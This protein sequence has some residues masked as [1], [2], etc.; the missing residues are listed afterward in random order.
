MQAVKDQLYASLIGEI[1]DYLSRI[2]LVANT[3]VNN[4]ILNVIVLDGWNGVAAQQMRGAL[5]ALGDY[6]QRQ[7]QMRPP[8]RALTYYDD[9]NNRNNNGYQRNW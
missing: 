1:Q 6:Y 2:K 3:P 9:N 4:F 5:G 8:P 7:Q